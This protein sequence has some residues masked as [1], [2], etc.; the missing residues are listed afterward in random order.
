MSYCGRIGG[1]E[2]GTLSS[3][4]LKSTKGLPPARKARLAM[5]FPRTQRRNRLVRCK[6]KPADSSHG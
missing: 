2:G 3:R 4:H 5:P 6:R 1:G